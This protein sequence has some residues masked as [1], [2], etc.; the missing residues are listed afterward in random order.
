MRTIIAGSR[1]ITNYQV[2]LDALACIDWTITEIISGMAGG[3]DLLGEQHAKENNIPLNQFPALWKRYGRQAGYL[4]N[5]EMAEN[6]DAC[7]VLW[8]G[9]SRGAKMMIDIAKQHKLYLLVYSKVF[10]QWMHE[11][12]KGATMI[13]PP[14]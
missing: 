5:V 14:F 4:R 13:K 6:A 8:D 12:T 1:S 2:L 10:G 7:I 3:A 9:Q 11:L